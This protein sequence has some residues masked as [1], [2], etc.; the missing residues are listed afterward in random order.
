M[1]LESCVAAGCASQ[2]PF[3]ARELAEDS[4]RDAG[5]GGSCDNADGGTHRPPFFGR[6]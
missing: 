4:P 6:R 2:C 1:A 3:V 5:D